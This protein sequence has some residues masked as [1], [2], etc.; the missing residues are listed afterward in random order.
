M[1]RSNRACVLSVLL[2]LAVCG[3]AVAARQDPEP[4]KD[5]PGVPR[6][7]GFLMN[8][9]TATDFNGFDFQISPEGATK[10]VEGRSWEFEYTLK[11]G[12]RHPSALE[13]ARN[14][15]NQFTKNGGK[16]VYQSP[17]ATESTMMMP[18]GGGERWFH[19]QTNGDSII[20]SIIETA[21]M[22]QKVEF[23]ADEMAAQVAA[24]GKIVLHG[25]LFDT[26]KTDITAASAPVLDEVA[27]LMKTNAGLKFRIDGHTDNV[28]ATAANLALSKGRA[29]SVKSALVARGVDAA[30]LTTDGL[31]DTKP[32]ADN[33]TEDGRRQNRRVELVKQ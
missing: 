27:V 16:V 31:G 30:R 14:Y 1:L 23:S 2:V 13:I 29:A 10:R 33:A 21:P 4:A 32:V 19:L 11:D 20:M 5:H 3:I 17:D 26:G 24:T 8:S 15:A 22:V 18:L 6:F 25:I 28:G 9:G 7:P 12:A